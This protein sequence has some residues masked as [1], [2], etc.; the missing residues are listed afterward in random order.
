VGDRADLTARVAAF[1]RWHYRIDLG[2]S[3]VTPIHDPTWVNRH[4]Q[5]R[6]NFFEPLVRLCGGTLRGRRVLDLACN[7]GYWSL[8]ALDA[9]ADFVLGV[10]GRQMH[11]D[12]ANLVMEARAIDPGRYRFE[13]ANVFEWDP[14]ETFDIVLCLGLLYHV[15]KPVEL[16]DRCA[17]WGSDLL[18]VDTSLSTLGR[19]AFEVFHE[20]ELEDPRTSVESTLVL[21]P[22]RAAVIEVLRAFGYD[23]VVLRPDFSSWEGAESYRIGTR[24][25]FLA[26][27]QTPLH[28]LDVERSPSRW[29]HARQLLRAQLL[30]R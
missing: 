16:F 15:A 14:G 21:A 19:P 13:V 2:H 6:R 1:P 9:G 23:A 24:R 8:L 27:K 22:S 20:V 18:V 3:V 11:V 12:Q 17:R 5:R 26:A 4:E 25:A 7:A 30:R 28:G 10:D 29:A